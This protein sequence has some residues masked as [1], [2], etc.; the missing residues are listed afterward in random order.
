[1]HRSPLL[2][3]HRSCA[4]CGGG[5]DPVPCGGEDGTVLWTGLA[6]WG[7]LAVHGKTNQVRSGTE[8]VGNSS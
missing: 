3:A 6:C 7:F 1:M 2:F 5:L 4:C 8:W